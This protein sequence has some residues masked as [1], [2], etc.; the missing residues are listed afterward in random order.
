MLRSHII[1]LTFFS[2][3]GNAVFYFLAQPLS[4]LLFSGR[5]E[6]FARDS[7]TMMNY[8]MMTLPFAIIATGC[9]T[10]YYARKHFLRFPFAQAIGNIINLTLIVLM[11]PTIG[12]W[13]LVIA[14]ILA[15]ATQIIIMYPVKLIQV[16]SHFHS[17]MHL[18]MIWIPLIISNFAM[19]SDTLIIRSFG[20]NLPEGNLVYL[21][22]ATRIFALASGVITIGIQV[23][24]LPHLV[25]YFAQKEYAAAFRMV[26]RSKMIGIGLSFLASFAV[27]ITAPF[28]L[29]AFFVGGSFRTE[30]A[31]A[32]I[33]LMPLFVLPAI[34][35]GIFSIFFQP[36]IALGKTIQVGMLSG[37]SFVCAWLTATIIQTTL[38]PLQGIVAGLIVLVFTGIIG[39]ELLWQHYK[40]KLLK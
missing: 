11:A 19:R 9:G 28:I 14:S 12:I 8:L 22:L 4:A 27:L 40:Q 25:E 20:S 30:D 35:W 34:G 10:Y 21:N 13:S 15:I 1:T 33:E 39:S 17:V 31:R 24:L 7:A 32:T 2:L 38:G 26:T 29:Y 18:V 5:G 16:P 37:F 36:L 3:L 23:L 6:G